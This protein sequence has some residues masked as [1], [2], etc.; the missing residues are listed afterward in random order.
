ME[1]SIT[2]V[3]EEW[4]R[5]IGSKVTALDINR[6]KKEITSFYRNKCRK[7]EEEVRK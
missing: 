7:D 3:I 2:R 1:K 5:E 4:N 6:L